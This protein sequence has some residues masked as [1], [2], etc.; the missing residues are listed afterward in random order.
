M[1]ERFFQ[2]AKHKIN[3]KTGIVADADNFTTMAYVG[4]L[5]RP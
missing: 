1:L 3:L 4:Y 2:L 5:F